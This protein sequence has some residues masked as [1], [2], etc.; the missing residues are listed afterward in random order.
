MDSSFP[1]CAYFSTLPPK[2]QL[3]EL[4]RR[5]L[6]EDTPSFDVSGFVAGEENTKATIFFKSAGVVAGIPFAQAVIDAAGCFVVWHCEEGVELTPN[7]EKGEKISVGTVS[8]RAC[9]VLLAE[10]TVLNILSRASGV[11]TQAREMKAI[12]DVHKWLGTVAGTRKVTPGFRMV[13]KYALV[14]GGVAP[15]RYDLSQMI[16]LKDNHINVT[17]SITNA[18]LK[19]K[20]AAGFSTKIEVECQNVDEAKEAAT[21]GADVVMLDNYTPQQIEK[22]SA[23]LKAQFPHLLIEASGGITRESIGHYMLNTVDVISQGCLTHGYSCV[24]VSMKI[25]R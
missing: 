6:R 16:M 13:E 23:E 3:E 25:T 15:H 21:A 19:A 12:A 8:G 5:Y 14:V 24:D 9:D 11:A 1:S 10:R 18:V 22:D 4:A 17:G 20:A 2:F 7:Q